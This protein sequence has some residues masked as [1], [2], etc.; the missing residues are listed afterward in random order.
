MG[1]F[2]CPKAQLAWRETAS[3]P[4]DLETI[5]NKP[6]SRILSMAIVLGLI[7]PLAAP[8]GAEGACTDQA[9]F[10]SDVTIP[11]YA[12]LAAGATVDKT[13]RLKNTGTCTWTTSY[14]MTFSKG[15]QMGAPK[16]VSMPKTVKPGETVDLKVTLKIPSSAGTY[17]GDYMLKNAQGKTFGLGTNAAY[18]F[19]VIVVV[20]TSSNSSSSSSSGSGPW[21]GEYYD[22]RNL[23]GRAEM[24]R[25]S[26]KIDYSWGSSSPDPDHFPPNSFSVRWKRSL[27]V[28]E[29]TYRF[30]LYASSGARLIVDSVVVIDAWSQSTVQEHTVDLDLAKGTHKIVVEY[31]H[32]TGKARVYLKWN[33]IG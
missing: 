6:I 5:M 22:S 13:W 16:S 18:S 14:A 9:G 31:F 2:T 15:D 17:R 30:R 32:R 19:W 26:D 21:K 27:T 20:K 28:K 23:S 33:K 3:N 29:G 10:V 25:Y 12:S 7:F 4:N 11:D 24:T 1:P 8:V